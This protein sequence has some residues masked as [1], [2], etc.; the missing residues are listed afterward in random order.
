MDHIIVGIIVFVF[1]YLLYTITVI[2]NKEKIK[3]FEKSGQASF[4]IKKYHLN[5]TK[6]NKKEFAHSIAIVNSF[7]ISV[8]FLITDFLSNYILKLLV[9][10]IVLVPLIL[11]GYHFLGRFYK[12]KEVSTHV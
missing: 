6:L 9:G 1:I 3:E 4:I 7:I 11:I 12:K 2:N 8:T 10:F 5:T